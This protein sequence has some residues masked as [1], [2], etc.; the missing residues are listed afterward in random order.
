MCHQGL[1]QPLIDLFQ[2]LLPNLLHILLAQSRNLV[3][4]VLSELCKDLI[5]MI[6]EKFGI[7]WLICIKIREL[8]VCI[9]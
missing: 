8:V 6:P 3:H 1:L 7:E 4:H 5:E 2:I 9:H